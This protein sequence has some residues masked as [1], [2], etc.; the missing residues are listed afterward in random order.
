MKKLISLIST[1]NKTEQQIV[2]E[3]WKAFGR[4]NKTGK[5]IKNLHKKQYLKDHVNTVDEKKKL[6]IKHGE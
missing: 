6:S 3:T 1:N 2:D 4:Y 5:T